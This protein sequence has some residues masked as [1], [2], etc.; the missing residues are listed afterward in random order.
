[1]WK[2]GRKGEKEKDGY[3]KRMRE[4]VGDL[5]RRESVVGFAAVVVACSAEG[6]ASQCHRRLAV[7]GWV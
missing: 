4:I 3:E 7:S 6:R 5:P 1:M 2:I